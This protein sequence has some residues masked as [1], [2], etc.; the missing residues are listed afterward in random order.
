MV[1]QLFEKNPAR[2]EEWSR[3][4]PLGRLSVPEEYR[5]ATVFL[6][7]SGSSFMTGYHLP[8]T[9]NNS[10]DLKIDGGHTAW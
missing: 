3:H 6:A 2:K 7:G 9:S 10:A 1:A 8:G 5:A 4:N